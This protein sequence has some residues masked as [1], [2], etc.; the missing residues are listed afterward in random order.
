MI[1]SR[2]KLIFLLKYD[3]SSK[4]CKFEDQIMKYL[5]LSCIISCVK[6]KRMAMKVPCCSFYLAMRGNNS[7]QDYILVPPLVK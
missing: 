3:L 4:N 2:F 1:R 5:N 6:V 7:Q